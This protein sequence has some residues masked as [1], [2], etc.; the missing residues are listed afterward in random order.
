MGRVWQERL[1]LAWLT[2]C[3]LQTLR[4]MLRPTFPSPLQVPMDDAPALPDRW[5]AGHDGGL[6][7]LPRLPERHPHR[8]T[9]ESLPPVRRIAHPASGM[10]IRS[11][12]IAPRAAD[13]RLA[14]PNQPTQLPFPPQCV[15]LVRK[16]FSNVFVRVGAYNALT[17]EALRPV[18]TGGGRSACRC[19]LKIAVVGHAAA[20]RQVSQLPFIRP[21]LPICRAGPT[22]A[23]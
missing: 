1:R 20:G 2:R 14:P 17:D 23:G 19:T 21:F 11:C 13:T 22:C 7:R 10:F 6:W 4:S 18:S 8:R 16:D 3:R 15:S 5:A 12:W 9:R